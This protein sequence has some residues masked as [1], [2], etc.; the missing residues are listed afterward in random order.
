[1]AGFLDLLQ[2]K[3]HLLKIRQDI[4][5]GHPPNQHAPVTEGVLYYSRVVLCLN[6]SPP[7][8]NIRAL[9]CVVSD[10]GFPFSSV[11]VIPVQISSAWFPLI[12]FASPG[13]G[14]HCWQEAL[15]NPPPVVV[16]L[17]RCYTISIT[18]RETGKRERE[19]VCVCMCV[20]R[21][22]HKNRHSSGVC[23]CEDSSFPPLSLL[24]VRLL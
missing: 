22:R 6:I 18:C 3:H 7:L 9:L 14:S 5:R 16:W 4:Y 15:V 23:K 1:M 8:K 12:Q 21:E 24:V 10:W 17:A 19:C 2:L 11:Q 13:N 20:L